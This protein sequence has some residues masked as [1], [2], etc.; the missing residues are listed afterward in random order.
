M[1][2][3]R[4]RLEYVTKEYYTYKNEM[5]PKQSDL[6]KAVRKLKEEMKTA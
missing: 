1:E 3:I 4:E 6:D 5:T 2:N